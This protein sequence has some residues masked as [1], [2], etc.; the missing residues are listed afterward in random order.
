MGFVTLFFI[1][2]LFDGRREDQ[3]RCSVH[4][5]AAMIIPSSRL[6]HGLRQL[7]Q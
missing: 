3:S 2:R 6:L 5:S 4:H 1:I 7:G